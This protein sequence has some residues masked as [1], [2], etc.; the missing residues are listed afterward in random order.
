MVNEYEYN[1]MLEPDINTK[2]H[3]NWFYFKVITKMPKG[4]LIYI[5]IDLFRDNPQIQYH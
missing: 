4:I 5:Y 1:L 2:G 3:T